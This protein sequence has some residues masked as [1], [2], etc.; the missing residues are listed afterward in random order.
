M[1]EDRKRGICEDCGKLRD[2]KRLT[3]VRRT[4]WLCFPCGCKALM[5][6]QNDGR[7]REPCASE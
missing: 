5:R 1:T 3:L 2:L 6:N 7:K 4:A